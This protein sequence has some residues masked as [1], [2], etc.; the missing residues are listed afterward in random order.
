MTMMDL[1]DIYLPNGSIVEGFAKDQEP[2]GHL[3]QV[4][5]L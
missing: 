3:D 5:D 4:H 1:P 2:T